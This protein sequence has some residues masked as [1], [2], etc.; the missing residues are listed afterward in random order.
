M[1]L[2]LCKTGFQ[3]WKFGFQN[4]DTGFQNR[5]LGIQKPEMRIFSSKNQVNTVTSTI[6]DNQNDLFFL[7]YFSFFLLCAMHIDLDCLFLF[8]NLFDCSKFWYFFELEGMFQFEFWKKLYM[9][10]V[11]LNYLMPLWKVFLLM[12]DSILNKILDNYLNVQI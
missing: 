5:K 11:V 1:K 7:S 10:L 3:N 2:S 12:L 6:C 9:C 4:W 8:R